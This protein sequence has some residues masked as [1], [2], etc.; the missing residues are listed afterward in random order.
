ML[1]ETDVIERGGTMPLVRIGKRSDITLP[2]DICEALD[3]RAGDLLRTEIVDG[4]VLLKPADEADKEKAW[5]QLMG[6]VGSAEW[7]GP[8]PEPSE[9]EIMQIAVEA[10]RE[11]RREKREGRS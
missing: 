9:D 11:V 6:L 3:V 5:N 8:G 1:G 7:T 10:V 4:G 2:D